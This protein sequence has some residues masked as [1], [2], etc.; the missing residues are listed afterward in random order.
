MAQYE[1]VLIGGG[2]NSLIVAA[3][4]AKAGTN[5]CVVEMKPYVGGGVITKE[6]TL[7]GF[8]HDLYST[9]HWFIRSNPLL[10]NDELKLQ[11]KYGLNYIPVDP[12]T[13]VVFPDESAIVFHKDLDKTCESIAKISQRDAETY[14]EFYAWSV[15]CLN[16]LTMGMFSPPPP[17]SALV[18]MLEKSEEG[19]EI[20]ISLQK[21]GLDIVDDWFESDKVKIALTRLASEVL[22]PPYTRGTGALLFAV[23]ASAQRDGFTVLQG[24][25]GSLT[26]SLERC[27]TDLG[28]TIRTSSPVTSI[29]VEGGEAKGVVLE[30]GEEI[31]ATKAVISTV[32]VKQLFLQM[33]PAE[34]LPPHF[35]TKVRR[36]K[37]SEYSAFVCSLALNEAPTY[38]AG[39]DVDHCH[40]NETA[41]HDMETYLKEFDA[42]R[43]G[44]PVTDSPLL[45]CNTLHDSTRA[46][47]GKH[48]L[49][50]YHYEPYDLKEGGA[51]RWDE[52]KEEVADTILNS[53]RHYTT[54]MGDEN[55]LGSYMESPLDIERYNPAWV[56]ADEAGIGHQ[57]FQTLSY[58]PLAGW[59]YKTPIQKLYMAGACTHPGGG[60]TGGGR[61]AVQVVMEDLGIDFRK[62]VS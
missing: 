45:V 34:D 35:Q 46:P 6:V 58:R 57:S 23:V 40:A 47:K 42:L 16:M 55:I 13:S 38:K 36:L 28:G 56:K 7:P 8:K 33:L 49:F 61:A 54:N 27:L 41:S 59:N 60:V 11:S 32:N 10:R 48:T 15:P 9:Q 3:Y 22:F 29:K 12:S 17:Y 39:G 53:V 20:L 2:H 24:G 52:I 14:R 37:H 1:V 50:V 18:S 31:L 5:V 43:Y 4:L 19:Q 51:A 62:V 44:Y 26:E 25:S 21:S 30:S